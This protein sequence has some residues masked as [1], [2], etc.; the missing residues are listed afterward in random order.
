MY[1]QDRRPTLR[2]VRSLNLCSGCC[3][4]K[5]GHWIGIPFIRLSL[6]SW[7]LQ[8]CISRYLWMG[9][10]AL[11]RQGNLFLMKGLSGWNWSWRLFSLCRCVCVCVCVCMLTWAWLPQLFFW[12]AKQQ[13]N[14]LVHHQPV[15]QSHNG[16][17][18]GNHSRPPTQQR[19]ENNI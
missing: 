14:S 18:L 2:N 19:N 15:F 4:R 11:E 13:P 8:V 3:W 10:G 9:L 1:F 7:N 12:K 17:G 6:G 16:G 5:V